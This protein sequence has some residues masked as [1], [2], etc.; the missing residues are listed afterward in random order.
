[1]RACTHKS[2]PVAGC[3]LYLV[4]CGVAVVWA[5]ATH[6]PE[7]ITSPLVRINIH[8]ESIMCTLCVLQ[9]SHGVALSLNQ[10]GVHPL[11]CDRCSVLLL[12]LV[13]LCRCSPCCSPK[14]S[15]F[16]PATVDHPRRTLPSADIEERSFDNCDLLQVREVQS[17]P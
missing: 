2:V 6:C 10:H 15:P 8:S 11:C 7:H 3:T 12:L 13:I 4:G 5:E 17:C 16:R 9:Q 14:I 1:M